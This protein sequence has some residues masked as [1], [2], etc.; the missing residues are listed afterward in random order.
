M[1][2]FVAYTVP[3]III[4]AG[5][6]VAVIIKVCLVVIIIPGAVI[7][8]VEMSLSTSG[9]LEIFVDSELFTRIPVSESVISFCSIE[10]ISLLY[11]RHTHTLV[12]FVAIH[13]SINGAGHYAASC[14]IESHACIDI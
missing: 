5:I 1:I 6:A 9:S 13:K 2:F 10:T 7:V 14:I 4:I 8:S 12:V 11:I 3:I